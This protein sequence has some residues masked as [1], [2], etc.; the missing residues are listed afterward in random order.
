MLTSHLIVKEADNQQL[1]KLLI[2]RNRIG[3]SIAPANV[4]KSQLMNRL[5]TAEKS[6]YRYWADQ[7]Q[8]VSRVIEI[9]ILHRVAAGTWTQG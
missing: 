7:Y 5:L 9:E 4:R 8:I 3:N 1:K 2:E 6:P